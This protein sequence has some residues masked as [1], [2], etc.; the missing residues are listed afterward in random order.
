MRAHMHACIHA[1][2]P[3]EMAPSP[4]GQLLAVATH[5]LRLLLID[6]SNGHMSQLDQADHDGGIFDLSWSLDGRWLAYAL[7][8][9]L[10]YLL[11]Y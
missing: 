9:L 5:D 3:L 11:T 1:G 4:Q 7:S 2:E 10:T 8:S 6:L